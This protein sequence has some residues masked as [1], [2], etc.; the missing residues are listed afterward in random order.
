MEKALLEQLNSGYS[1]V[2]T[3]KLDL[4]LNKTNDPS[5]MKTRNPSV[6]VIIFK[7]YFITNWFSNFIMKKRSSTL[8]GCSSEDSSCQQ[9]PK[10]HKLGDFHWDRRE[11]FS[12]ESS[13]A[14][15]TS[16]QSSTTGSLNIASNRKKKKSDGSQVKGTIPAH[17]QPSS[18]FVWKIMNEPP[19]PETSVRPPVK[20]V[21]KL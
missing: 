21:L 1:D 17:C 13:N 14:P 7:F 20:L 18:A 15:S 8:P 10:K 16:D 12:S 2:L 6:I 9:L 4:S 19:I 3:N 5:M 11:E